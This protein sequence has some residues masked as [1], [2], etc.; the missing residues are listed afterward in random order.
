MDSIYPKTDTDKL[1]NRVQWT[2]FPC[3]ET[4]FIELGFY[5]WKLSSLN[6]VSIDGNRVHWTR[7]CYWGYQATNCTASSWFGYCLWKPLEF[8]SPL[9]PPQSVE[10]VFKLPNTS[11]ICRNCSIPW[12]N[13]TDLIKGFKVNK[14]WSYVLIRNPMVYS[15]KR[16]QSNQWMLEKKKSKPDRNDN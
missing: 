3:I 14:D 10:R 12:S 13:Y 8:S 6:S 11:P 7:F 15:H 4:E 5:T 9:I 1:G 2:Q 16:D